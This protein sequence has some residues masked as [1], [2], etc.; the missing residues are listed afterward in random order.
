[1]RKLLIIL[2]VV[3]G[4]VVAVGIGLTW[5]LKDPNRFKPELETLIEQNTGM[6]VSLDGDL[7]WQLWPPVMLTAQ[8]VAFEDD[9]S[10]YQLERLALAARL[11]ALLSSGELQI[12]SIR[13]VDLEIRDKRFDDVT[14]VN[15]FTVRNFTE[16][17]AFPLQADITLVDPDE[18]DTPVAIAA[19]ATFDSDAD[20][21]RLS[22]MAVDYDGIDAICDVT[23]S[24]LSRDPSMDHQETRDDL[25]PLDTF[26]SLD[27]VADCK[28]P[29]VAME[30]VTLRDVAIHSENTGARSKTDINV[31]ALF[32]G[33]L[34]VATS[35]DATSRVPVWSV[36]P[37]AKDLQSQQLMDVVSPKL[38]WVA[39]LLVGGDFTMRGNT[40]DELASSVRGTAKI[41]AG[42]GTIDISLLKSSVLALA[43]LAGQ[44][45][46][47]AGWPDELNYEKLAGDWKVEGRTHTLDLLLDNMAIVANGEYDPI[48][49]AM[50]MRGALT[51]NEHPSLSSFDINPAL[52][53]APIP[54]R[55]T[56]TTE[57]PDC[58]LDKSEAQN[59]LQTIAANRARSE[60][61]EKLDEAISDKVPEEYQ[62]KARE[63][64]KGLGGLLN[65]KKDDG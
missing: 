44:G 10:V 21:L 29:A 5:M 38:S 36:S 34:N 51:V 53:G 28:A 16:G 60:I 50:D 15:S 14:R 19:T 11:G 64:L 65:R 40:A 59:T 2:G 6:R 52:Y 56:G 30:S 48:S 4:L 13:L 7:D 17:K 45:E 23:V 26:R 63:A 25:L 49:G 42:T 39:P 9:E 55:C 54:I 12:Q 57:E 58:G 22:E 31:P 1:M 27:W 24:N 61:D 37:D 46:K 35:I 8:D 62:D 41:D 32:G 3:I 33:S 18:G 43:E 47:V 20:T